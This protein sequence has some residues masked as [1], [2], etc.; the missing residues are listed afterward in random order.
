MRVKEDEQEWAGLPWCSDWRTGLL[1]FARLV[2]G[3]M[4]SGCEVTSSWC[5]GGGGGQGEFGGGGGLAH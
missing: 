3:A 1:G 4:K 2:K 5:T